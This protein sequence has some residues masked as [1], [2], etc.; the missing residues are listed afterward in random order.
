MYGY[1]VNVTN[2]MPIL[3]SGY[4]VNT[5]DSIQGEALL[6][7]TLPFVTVAYKLPFRD[8]SINFK[9]IR[10][11]TVGFLLGKATNDAAGVYQKKNSGRPGVCFLMVCQDNAI[12]FPNANY[13]DRGFTTVFD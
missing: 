1:Y 3:M 10:N 11:P 7:H 9:Y 6:K 8:S 5:N 13:D 12:L 2:A 4:I